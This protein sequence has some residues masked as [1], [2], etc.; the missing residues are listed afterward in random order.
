MATGDPQTQFC[1][2]RFSGYRDMLE[3]RQTDGLITVLRTATGTE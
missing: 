2:D 3:D 1:K